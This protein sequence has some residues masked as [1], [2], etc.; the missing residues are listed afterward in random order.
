ME[1]TI[2]SVVVL[3]MLLVATLI[4]ASVLLTWN[5]NSMEWFSAGL[6]PMK[7]LLTGGN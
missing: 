1:L 6:E 7:K 3:F 5:S 2:R 4:I